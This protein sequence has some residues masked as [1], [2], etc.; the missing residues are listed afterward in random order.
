MEVLWSATWVRQ[1][2]PLGPFLSWLCLSPSL[3][4]D[5][6]QLPQRLRA[7]GLPVLPS[8]TTSS[9]PRYGKTTCASLTTSELPTSPALVVPSTPYGTQS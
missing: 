1:G 5:V 9:H 8:R 3:E 2:D 7:A 6:K 4:P